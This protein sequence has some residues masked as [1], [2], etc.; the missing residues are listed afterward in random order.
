[1][2]TDYISR[3]GLIG[4]ITASETQKTL[5]TGTG[6]DAYGEILRIICECPAVKL[7]RDDTE[8]AL[9]ARKDG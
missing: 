8:K 3:P 4:A 7:T 1:M 6:E 5:R 2:A 9:E